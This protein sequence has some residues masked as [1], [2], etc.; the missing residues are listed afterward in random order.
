MLRLVEGAKDFVVVVAVDLDD[1]PAEA[2]PALGRLTEGH[3][4][5]GGSVDLQAVAV[6]DGAEVVELVMGGGHRGLPD[7]AL[8]RL[9]VSEDAVGAVVAVVQAGRKGHADRAR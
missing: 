9:A 4:L 3:D 6:E 8:L 5:F 7:L 1:V 2:A